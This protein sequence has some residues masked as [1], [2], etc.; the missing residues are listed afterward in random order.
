M[1]GA[2]F[3]KKK[4]QLGDFLSFERKGRRIFLHYVKGSAEISIYSEGIL[5]VRISDREFEKD[6]SYAVDKD[7]EE[8][9]EPDVKVENKK[10]KI[11]LKTSKINLEVTKF[12]LNFR[13]Y[14]EGKETPFLEDEKGY[15]FC[16]DEEEIRTFKKLKPDEHFYGFGEKTGPLDKRGESMEMF[17][18]DRAYKNDEDPL[19][20]SIPFFVGVE[21]G[22]AYGVFFDNTYRS[23]FDMG[24]SSDEVFSFGAD[25]G[26]MDYYVFYGPE[27]SEVIERYTELTG[28][29]RLPP[30]WAIGY[31]QSRWSYEPQ[32]KVLE[33]G[34]K[35]VEKEIPCDAIH[36][37]IDYMDGYRVFTFDDEKFPNP[38]KMVNK[39]KNWG[40]T[41]VVINDPGIKEDE[42]FHIYR[43][44]MENEYYCK[45]PEGGPAKSVMWPG[46]CIFPDYTRSEVREWW[47]D[48]HKYY[49]DL[50]IEGI[51]NDMN[52]PSIPVMDK[53]DKL[54][55]N[56]VILKTF[57]L[58][59]HGRYSNLKRVRNV[60]G[61]N[62][63][64][65]TMKGFEKH[66]PNKRP[67]ILTRSGYAGVQKYAAIWT[68]DNWSSFH[69]IGLSL[70]MIMNLGLS[71]VPFTG[72]D[73]G[74]FS[75]F[76]KY[77]FKDSEL[78]K[79]WIQTGVFYPFSRSHT[80]KHTKDQEPWS[81]GP[82][83]EEI[84]RRYIKL[85]Y[86][87]LPYLYTLFR[88]ASKTGQPIMRPLFYNYQEDE[89][90]YDKKFENQFMLGEDLL[91]VP[92]SEKDFDSLDFYL[93]KEDYWTDYWDGVDY[94][95]G[96]IHSLESPL[97]DVPVFV[98]AGTVLPTHRPIQ[99]TKER[100]DKLNIKIYP[101]DGSFTLYE[102]DGK[103]KEY[104]QGKY[105]TID[106]DL[107]LDD[108]LVRLKID[109]GES[110]GFKL[111]YKN[112]EFRV[113]A[114]CNADSVLVDGREVSWNYK[115]VD[116]V[117]EFKTDG[118]EIS[119]VKLVF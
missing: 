54:P 27:I 23:H 102:D 113:H 8:F 85:R 56:D 6:V 82:E 39:L 38:E 118:I 50:G 106:F 41:T 114:D 18:G 73:I 31:H 116:D 80:A 59:D 112:Y 119:E 88:E 25:G 91:V 95:G 55:F 5:R 60:Y 45:N 49:F 65:G 1:F 103:S 26:E 28:R 33:I 30:K 109:R 58:Y 81:Y 86:K 96:G 46:I 107:S 104:R 9:E 4:N 92:I 53:F 52:E 78:Y 74:G 64:K 15:S 110:N 71:G 51:W 57:H 75:G 22:E 47:G 67:F 17:A 99:N 68:G 66:L 98:R 11:I 37:D 70:R 76:A 111:P 29:M 117:I 24:E 61:L 89:V 21:G 77:L 10:D 108:S 13:F 69:Q 48:L 44:C 97:R 42:D 101:G 7:L 34:E 35:F 100:V 40:I 19:Y 12:P 84:S 115:S 79:R 20:V 63:N 72:A 83:V 87:L 16:R 105:A 90:C 43:Q 93:P 62:E 36:L 3:E 94:Q 14:G 2:G 32:E